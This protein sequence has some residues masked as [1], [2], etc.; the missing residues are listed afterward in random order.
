MGFIDFIPKYLK[1]SVNGRPGQVVPAD[2]W[3]EYWNL[4]I[5]QG[6]YNSEALD[7]LINTALPAFQTNIQNQ[8]NALIAFTVPDKSITAIKIADNTITN[9]Q[10]AT[11]MKKGIANGVASLDTE[12]KV[13]LS[14]LP[15]I[16]SGGHIISTT[17][18]TNTSMLWIDT[19][20]GNRTKY[21]NG[22]AWTP[23]VTTAVW[24]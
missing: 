17:P 11:T 4:N 3:N 18:P 13:P 15:P 24:G 22:T 7:N 14:Q 5:E 9:A 2:E 20:D 16:S 12:G 6:D 1:F 8:I 19:T 10:M 21:W 23:L